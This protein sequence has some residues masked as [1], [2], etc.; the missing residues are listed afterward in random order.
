MQSKLAKE[1][2]GT[3]QFVD[4]FKQGLFGFVAPAAAAQTALSVLQNTAQSFV[5]AFKFKAS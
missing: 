5:D 4:A 2:S 1:L 3:G